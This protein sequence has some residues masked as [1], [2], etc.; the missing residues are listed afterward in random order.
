VLGH[1]GAAGDVIRRLT[2]LFGP[3]PVVHGPSVH[4]LTEAGRSARAALAG[5]VAARAWPSAPRPVAADD[6]L[7]ER[8]L[9]G[10][11][12]ARRALVDR[13]YLRLA[14][15]EVPLLETTASYLEH[16]RSLEAAAR[17]LF[18]HPNTV[19]YRLKRVADLTGW[20][21]VDPREGFVLHVAIVA[22]RL[23]EP[24]SRGESTASHLEETSK[25]R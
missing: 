23:A 7:P 6:L 20:D 17:A 12:T 2:E 10:D 14:R 9:S 21:P 11:A 15:S 5:V 19:R 25:H 4:G 3:G 8:L 16:G 13:A 1:A 24:R 22:G 18:V